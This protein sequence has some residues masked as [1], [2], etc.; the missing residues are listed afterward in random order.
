MTKTTLLLGFLISTTAWASERTLTV[1]LAPSPKVEDDQTLARAKDYATR[2]YRP[3]GVDLRWKSKCSQAR[4]QASGT[5][6]A[7][8]LTTLGIEWAAT[9]P[10]NV[11]ADAFASARPSQPT[12]MR[13]TLYKDRVAS[14]GRDNNQAA[15]VLG[16][17]LAHE[18]GHILLG[19]FAHAREGLMQAN[20]GP[21][22]QSTM[23][24]RLLSFT[25]E[26]AESIRNRLDGRTAPSVPASLTL[27]K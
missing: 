4:L 20:L 22:P 2:L 24:W 21:S 11:A 19:R 12:G 16:H 13:I 23:Q 14:L 18:I 25:P 8:N 6:E 9:H 27:A 7:P 5:L 1:C 26:E 3:I 10:A 15:A 17:V